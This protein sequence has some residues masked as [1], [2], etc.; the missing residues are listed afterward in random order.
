M[1]LDVLLTSENLIA[2]AISTIVIVSLFFGVYFI[3][4]SIKSKNKEESVEGFTNRRSKTIINIVE[5]SILTAFAVV[6]ELVFKLI[7]FMDMPQGGSFSLAMLPILILA[8][9]RGPLYGCLGGVIFGIINLLID[10]VLYHWSSFFLDYTVAF[11]LIGLAGIFNPLLK[12]N[13]N[14]NI[15]FLIIGSILGTFLR[16]CSTVLSGMIAFE[17]PFIGS[18]IYNAPYIAVSALM[19]IVI[20]VALNRI[21]L[22]GIEKR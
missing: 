20:I 12:E 16:L 22:Y 17:T 10:G 13:S 2:I 21:L 5:T 11:G 14:R 18:V 19:C 6:L 8:F 1:F 3:M 9:R 15:I 7:P 4:K